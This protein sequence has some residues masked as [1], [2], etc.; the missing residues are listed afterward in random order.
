V[1]FSTNLPKSDKCMHDFFSRMSAYI[2]RN[3]LGGYNLEVFFDNPGDTSKFVLLIF[4]SQKNPKVQTT[5]A[6][7]GSFLPT[8]SQS[9]NRSQ[10]DIFPSSVCSY[11][12]FSTK[13]ASHVRFCPK[14]PFNYPTHFLP[15]CLGCDGC[16]TGDPAL[17]HTAL[18]HTDGTNPSDVTLQCCCQAMGLCL[19][20]FYQ[21]SPTIDCSMRGMN[22][23]RD[24]SLSHFPPTFIN[25]FVSHNKS[26]VAPSK[27]ALWRKSFSMIVSL[28]GEWSIR[29]WESHFAE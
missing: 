20:L 15:V 5:L 18:A 26:N 21:I 22:S 2:R 10:P 8:T 25:H 4:L 27:S 1:R 24:S 14:C 11:S 16:E 28:S 7:R 3:C 13:S 23:K 19:Q 6:E 12:T 29:N 9:S 17:A